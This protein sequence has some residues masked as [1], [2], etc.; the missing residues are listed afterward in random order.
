MPFKPKTHLCY[1]NS[2]KMLTKQRVETPEGVRY[3][4]VDRLSKEQLET[5]PVDVYS[6]ESQVASGQPL[7]RV[8]T[9]VLDADIPSE[10]AINAIAAAVQQIKDYKPENKE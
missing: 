7:K 2:Y 10:T 8:N 5:P 9:A 6:L 4:L 3:E 1:C